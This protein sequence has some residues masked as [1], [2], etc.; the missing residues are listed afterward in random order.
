M[1]E[2]YL[3]SSLL[4]KYNIDINKVIGNNSN[5]LTY[6]GYQEID[7]TLDYLINDLKINQHN[8]EK[9]PS[10][11]YR[12]VKNIKDNV[13]FLNT[14]QVKFE[15]IETCL[16]VLS[17]PTKELSS[18]YDYVEK[19][20]GTNVINKITSILAV[21]REKII[22]IENLNIPLKNKN[23]IISIAIGRNDIA[24]IEK[25]I[26]SKEFKEYP[27]LFTSTVL[28][29]SNIE[30]IQ[31]IIN[32]EEFKEHPKLFTSTVLARS[33]IEKMQEII[34]SEEFKEHRDLFTSQVLAHSSIEKIQEIINSEEFKEHPELFTSTVLAHSSIEKIQEI[35]NSEEFKEHPELFTSTVLAFSSIEKIK[36]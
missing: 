28:A 11:L 17:S 35:M 29:N 5:I 27:E 20:Y 23:D 6:G 14:K 36:K 31:E 1:I 16:H 7:R 19:N 2:K 18:T 30:K 3:L 22:S 12:N 4:E 15:N 9:C 21:P 25:L 24:E 33:S 10:I 26:K 8:I 13:K 34:K 32:S